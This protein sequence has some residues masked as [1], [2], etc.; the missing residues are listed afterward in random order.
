MKGLIVSVYKSGDI[1]CTNGGPS[2]KFNRFVLVD[3]DIQGPF[4][5]SDDIPAMVLV[6]RQ[7]GGREYIHAVPASLADK[8]VMF[9]GNFVYTS[10]SRLSAVA[11]YPIPV[12][13]RVE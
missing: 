11:K 3:K 8:Q 10:D 6:R 4:S 12:H 7:L 13:D 5:P 9:G 1:D 2:S